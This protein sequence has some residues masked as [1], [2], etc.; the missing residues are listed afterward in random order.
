M[1]KI[2]T[3]HNTLKVLHLQGKAAIYGN[4]FHSNILGV[5]KNSHFSWYGF[6]TQ[7]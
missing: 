1:S 5:S 3:S 2:T 6:D 7:V 4:V